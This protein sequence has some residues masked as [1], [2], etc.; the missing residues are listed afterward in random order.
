MI[1]GKNMA[2]LVLMLLMCVWGNA[3]FVYDQQ[4]YLWPRHMPMP[5]R[6]ENIYTTQRN[7]RSTIA[8]A[9]LTEANVTCSN[10]SVS[11]KPYAFEMM[12]TVIISLCVLVFLCNV[13][14]PVEDVRNH[15]FKPH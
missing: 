3:Q 9:N 13:L 7:F 6:R 4:Y 2:A 11:L 12:G 8:T 5:M 1:N 14:L 10:G 15:R